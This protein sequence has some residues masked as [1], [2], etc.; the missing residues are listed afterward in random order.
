M[1]IQITSDSTCD[2]SPALLERFH[3]A[4]IPL[5]VVKDG[6]AY[7]DGVD[8]TPGQIFAH[9]AAGGAL[10]STSAVSEADYEDFFARMLKDCDGLVHVTISSKM[11]ACYQNACNAAKR[12]EHVQI[13]DSMNLSTAQGLVVLSGAEL[14]LQGAMDEKQI[15]QQMRNIV[16]KVDASFIPE[17]LDYLRKGGRCSAVAA[18]G[19]NLLSIK[20]CIEVHDGAMGVAKKYRGAFE[21]TLRNYIRERLEG[22]DTLDL[23]RLIITHTTVADG[24]VDMVREEV[25]RCQPFAEI[26]VTTAQCTISCHC[27][28]NTLGILYIHK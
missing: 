24:V 23:S 1:K 18:L 20:P 3:V 16:P 15:A 11:S 9:V 5:Y 26:L 12:F 17:S 10:C 21:K 19:A 27:G 7:R 2:L 4:T 13:V 6:V 22:N 14:A 8:I 28:P 25:L